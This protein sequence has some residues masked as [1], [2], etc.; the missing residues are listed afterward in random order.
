MPKFSQEFSF[1]EI[2]K[3]KL[4]LQVSLSGRKHTLAL[5]EKADSSMQENKATD[6]VLVMR[7]SQKC[8][9]KKMQGML[10]GVN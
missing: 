5:A 4:S 7:T 10:R 1:S 8:Y 9:E 6:V 2:E 3:S